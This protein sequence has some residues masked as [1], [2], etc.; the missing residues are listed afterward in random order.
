M[1][2]KPHRTLTPLA[3][4]VLRLLDTRPMHPY[5]M[6]Q[7][8]RDHGTDQVIKVRA[9]SL[10]HTVERLHRHGLIEQLE[11]GREGRRPER[12]V[13]AIT[14]AGRDEFVTN[15]RDL[16]RVPAE[17]FPLFAAALEMAAALP[18]ATVRR[19]LEHRVVA[20]EA[21]LAGYEQAIG[22]LTKRGLDRVNL[23][24]AEFGLHACRAELTWVRQIVAEIDSGDLTW[25]TDEEQHADNPRTIK[26]FAP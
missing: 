23:I 4:A 3:L 8:V 1:R 7:V 14:D 6:H 10:Y 17:E 15:L 11:T 13:Y 9:G 26:E 20:L 22:T 5:E 24:E 2:A 16:L 18:P 21:H 19:L 25:S 12:T